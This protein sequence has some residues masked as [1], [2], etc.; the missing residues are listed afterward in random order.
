L[1][2][3]NFITGGPLAAGGPGQLPP[4]PLLNPDLVSGVSRSRHCPNG[5]RVHLSGPAC[6]PSCMRA[7]VRLLLVQRVLCSD[8]CNNM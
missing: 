3:P 8:C 1:K 2:Q 5:A 6:M 4:L 7:E